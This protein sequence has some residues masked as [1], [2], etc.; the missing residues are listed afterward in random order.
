M[1][2]AC[3]DLIGTLVHLSDPIFGVCIFLTFF[4]LAWL[5]K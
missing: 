5:L 3:S 4:G 1:M 2:T